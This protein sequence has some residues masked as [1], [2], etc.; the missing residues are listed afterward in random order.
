[1]TNP[2]IRIHNIETDKIVDR[3]MNDKELAQYNIDNAL[4][5]SQQQQAI[6]K[7]NAKTSALAKLAALG[8][9]D[10]EIAALLL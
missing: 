2:M 3:E 10:D 5:E 8:L 9:T 1:M 7:E 4:I 6:L